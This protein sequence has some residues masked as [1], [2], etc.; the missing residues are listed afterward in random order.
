VTTSETQHGASRRDKLLGLGVCTLVTIVIIC[1]TLDVR[2]VA[3]SAIALLQGV[4]AARIRSY[5]ATR[6]SAALAIVRLLVLS[7][8]VLA[9]PVLYFTFGRALGL[10]F[11]AVWTGWTV[12]FMI[13]GWSSR[14]SG[15]VPK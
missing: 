5:Q 9:I 13:A 15:I 14:N 4:A 1:I 10:P 12:G 3:S 7:P 6:D 11:I 8:L 2:V